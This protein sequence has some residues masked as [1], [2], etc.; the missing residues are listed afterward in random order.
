M[1]IYAGNLQVL[2]LITLIVLVIWFFLQGFTRTCRVIALLGCAASVWAILHF[3]VL[4][5]TPS[6]E[7]SFVFSA[8]YTNEF[9]RE[10]FM[11]A[12][13]YVPLG[14]TLSVL[15]GSRAVAFCLILS[16]GI[17]AWQYFAGAGLAQ[18]TDVIMN[19]L[20]AAAGTLP[21]LIRKASDGRIRRLTQTTTKN[22]IHDDTTA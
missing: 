9:Y 1:I 10:M 22:P 21:Y 20:G 8:A 12:L 18:A 11:N 5:R 16:A 13:L 2:T 19:T 15:T 14:M 17:E 4:G 6:G 7:R 3:T